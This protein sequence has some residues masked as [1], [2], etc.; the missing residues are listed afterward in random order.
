[1]PLKIS[2]NKGTFDVPRDFS[3]EIEVNSPL[4]NEKGSQSISSTIPY[5]RNNRAMLGPIDRL[6]IASAPSSDQKAIVSDGSFMRR[7]LL[8]V[9]SAS[10]KEGITLNVGLDESVMYDEWSDVSLQDIPNLPKY[11][12]ASLSVLISEM[13]QVYNGDITRDYT[14]FQVLIK[15]DTESDVDYDFIL[16]P[17]KRKSEDVASSDFFKLVLDV[18]RDTMKQVV[19][20]TVTTVTIPEGYC[21]CPFL[22]VYRVLELLFSAYGYTLTENPFYSDPQLRSLVLLHNVPDILCTGVLYYKDMM[23]ECTI[24]DL[25]DS[26]KAHFAAFV[27]VNSD[28]MTARI[29]MFRD[30]SA[31]DDK[32]DWTNKLTGA[33][34][35]TY[36]EP[37]Q[38]KLSSSTGFDGAAPSD[39]SF[40][41]MFK[42]YHGI[43]HVVNDLLHNAT[44][45][46]DYAFLY[47]RNDGMYYTIDVN[48][49]AITA[50]ST[51]FFE[52]DRET[53]GI[54]YEEISGSDEL[55]PFKTVALFGLIPYY[56]AGY[57]H[58]HTTLDN[59]T[60]S[61]DSTTTTSSTS[62][63]EKDTPL[64]F[65]FDAGMVK[66]NNYST[67]IVPTYR[68]GSSTGRQANGLRALY[69]GVQ[70]LYSLHYVGEDGAF[71]R[72]WKEY[73]SIL[74]WSNHTVETSAVLSKKDI[75]ALDSVGIIR[76][77]GQRLLLDTLTYTLPILGNPETDITLRTTRLYD[78]ADIAATYKNFEDQLYKWS[79]SSNLQQL[80]LQAY[81]VAIAYLTANPGYGNLAHCFF[82]GGFLINEYSE[83][84]FDFMYPPTAAEFAAGKTHV[85]QIDGASSFQLV[86]DTSYIDVVAAAVGFTY[87]KGNLYEIVEVMENYERYY[88]YYTCKKIVNYTYTLAA[89]M[90]V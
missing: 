70:G 90:I 11:A 42:K 88:Y 61:S 7:G 2:T 45:L 22:R 66:A 13:V 28:T 23:P 47:S 32:V 76:V 37:K 73:D 86:I 89:S 59:T 56:Q 5:T 63:D 19:D 77:N 71:N 60:S 34:L 43:C 29:V 31:S 55:V 53:A 20:G 14:L 64:S 57:V 49:F 26:L 83:E 74:R 85:F 46:T 78:G 50:I 54:D 24:N 44:S 62:D 21:I 25:L 75:A 15:R 40:E 48:T 82:Q 72:F 17:L 9:D 69:N 41:T 58:R 30:I 81:N 87:E 80:A 27:V 6:D 52:Y 16:N 68:F 4:Y 39:D 65:L 51:N 10:S 84:K 67:D 33:P 8:N 35:I 1:M 38:L 3:M 79:K 12:P 36:N 18:D